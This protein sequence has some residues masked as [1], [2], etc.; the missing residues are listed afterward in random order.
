MNDGSRYAMVDCGV[1][2]AFVVVRSIW[3]KWVAKMKAGLPMRRNNGRDGF[4]LN[5][6]SDSDGL[7]HEIH[8]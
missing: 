3:Q 1:M 5:D 7:T 4:L 8:R 6:G 2:D